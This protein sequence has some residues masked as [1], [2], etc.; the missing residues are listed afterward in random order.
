MA[1]II[2]GLNVVED[3]GIPRKATRREEKGFAAILTQVLN[4]DNSIFDDIM[5]ENFSVTPTDWRIRLSKEVI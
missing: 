5:H 4:N 3:E 2:S 1:I